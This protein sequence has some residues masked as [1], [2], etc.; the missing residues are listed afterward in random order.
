MDFKVI[1]VLA[2]R[3]SGSKSFSWSYSAHISDVEECD[4]DVEKMYAL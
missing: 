1:P 4:S 3:P 2:K